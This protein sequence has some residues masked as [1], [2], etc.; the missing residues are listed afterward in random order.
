MALYSTF[1]YGSGIKY[2]GVLPGADSIVIDYSYLDN[3]NLYYARMK[4]WLVDD[5]IYDKQFVAEPFQKLEYYFTGITGPEQEVK[6]YLNSKYVFSVTSKPNNTFEFYLRLSR[7]QNQIQCETIRIV[8]SLLLKSNVL[9]IN[10]YNLYLWLAAYA[11]EFSRF[12]G[13]LD[14]KKRNVYL[15]YADELG[16]R[17]NFAVFTE[18]QRPELYDPNQF[19]DMLRGTLMAHYN[20]TTW[21]SF[22]DFLF[23]FCSKVPTLVEYYK[24]YWMPTW[25]GLKV[26]VDRIAHPGITL[27]YNYNAGQVFCDGQLCFV[28]DGTGTAIDDTTTYVYTDGDKDPN[29]Y[30]TVKQTITEPVGDNIHIMAAISALGGDITFIDGCRRLGIDA[31]YR[32]RASRVNI[33]EVGVDAT[34]LVSSQK[35]TIQNIYKLLKP[36]HKICY[37]RFSDEADAR[38]V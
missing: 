5:K 30:L 10:A 32:S 2:K 18:I 23:A 22:Q 1:K 15:K 34:G 26:Y 17:N 7:G 31:I 9:T 24:E 16:L 6:V 19:R 25:S 29:G 28:L 33:F 35:D 3:L 11:D 13:D 4:N 20:S 38:T 12:W 36:A 8:D 14:T 21:E 37:L 27:E